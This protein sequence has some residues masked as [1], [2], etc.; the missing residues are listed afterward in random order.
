[1]NRTCTSQMGVESSARLDH[2]V[3]S[4]SISAAATGFLHWQ[5]SP[6]LWERYRGHTSPGAS[7]WAHHIKNSLCKPPGPRA[8]S[9]ARHNH[10]RIPR[11]RSAQCLSQRRPRATAL[12]PLIVNHYQALRSR[13]QVN[14]NLAAAPSMLGGCAL[15]RPYGQSCRI[16]WCIGRS[17]GSLS[18]ICDSCPGR[19]ATDGRPLM[20]TS[21]L[22]PR[23]TA[24]GSQP[25]KQL[26]LPPAPASPAHPA[27]ET[28]GPPSP[29][30]IPAA[31]YMSCSGA[32]GG[33][34]SRLP[35]HPSPS[36]SA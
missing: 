5:T 19:M 27:H 3:F 34:N 30:G 16:E 36:Q 17:G 21:Q 25:D 13:C 8:P 33:P 24:A 15:S 1:M 4:R 29:T 22:R 2:F 6:H 14:Q 11:G 10:E 9:T 26:D 7:S 18:P 12:G 28:R 35:R 23:S 20:Q 31:S 32:A